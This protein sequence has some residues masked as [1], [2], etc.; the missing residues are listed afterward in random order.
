MIGPTIA[1]VDAAVRLV[2][3]GTR[4]GAGPDRRPSGTIPFAGRLLGERHIAAIGPE[5]VEIQVTPGTVITPIA[6]DALKRRGIAVRLVSEARAARAGEWG[7]V[8]ED[9]VASADAIRRAILAAPGG[10][11]EVGGD[12]IEAA[13]WVAG[14]IDRGAV[15]ITPEASVACWLAAQV[16]GVRSAAPGDAD[17]VARAADRLGANLIVLEPAGHPIPSLLHCLK[18]FRRAGA[19]EAPAW[20]GGGGFAYEDRRS[21]WPGHVLAHPS[22]AE[23]SEVPGRRTHAEGGDRRWLPEERG[24]AG[25]VR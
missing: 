18:V 8:L 19:P 10:W 24:G 12:A 4:R 14:G 13:R 21:D 7:F 6:R 16:P 1:Q 2:L 25:R 22:V 15:V 23:E 11:D 20:L 5:V 9:G 17:A 3:A